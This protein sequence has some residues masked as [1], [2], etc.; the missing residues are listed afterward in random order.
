MAVNLGGNW[1]S[2]G[3]DSFTGSTNSSAVDVLDARMSNSLEFDIYNDG[4]DDWI[5]VSGYNEI[6]QKTSGEIVYSIDSA[7]HGVPTSGNYTVR[8]DTFDNVYYATRVGGNGTDIPY[9]VDGPRQA[10]TISDIQGLNSIGNMPEPAANVQNA[11]LKDVDI[12]MVR[13]EVL[14]NIS[15]HDADQIWMTLSSADVD[16]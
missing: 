10:T 2:S 16:L 8:Y 7:T 15:G 4:T 5:E 14:T 9:Y 6:H 11:I 12:I 13:D 3:H 1:N